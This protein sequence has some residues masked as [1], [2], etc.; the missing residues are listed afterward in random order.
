MS[1]Q[2]S[3]DLFHL[4]ENFF[5]GHSSK[6]MILKPHLALELPAK[7]FKTADKISIIGG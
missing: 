2:A 7:L 1:D 4:P 5:L 3:P 6:S